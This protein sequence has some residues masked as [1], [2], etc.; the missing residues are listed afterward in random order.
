MPLVEFYLTPNSIGSPSGS[1]SGPPSG[2]YSSSR[3]YEPLI[4]MIK[5]RTYD[6]EVSLI[7][8]AKCEEL[9]NPRSIM[10]GIILPSNNDS[11]RGEKER[12]RLR[13]TE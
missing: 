3:K 2:P 7:S 5:L 4:Q 8:E 12:L 1:P 6:D 10:S 9:M 13:I 11:C